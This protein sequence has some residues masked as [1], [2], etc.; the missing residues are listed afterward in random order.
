MISSCDTL[1]FLTFIHLGALE[2]MLYLLSQLQRAPNRKLIRIQS[3]SLL[4]SALIPPQKVYV[5]VLRHSD[6]APNA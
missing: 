6:Q 4:G 5:L 2:N 3:P 1:L